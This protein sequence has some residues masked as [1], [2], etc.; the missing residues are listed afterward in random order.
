METK[1]KRRSFEYLLCDP[2]GDHVFLKFTINW[3]SELLNQSV[4]SKAQDRFPSGT[5]PFHI[6]QRPSGPG[7]LWELCGQPDTADGEG[8]H[9]APL[10]QLCNDAEIIQLPGPNLIRADLKMNFASHLNRSLFLES[11]QSEK[12]KTI[13]CLQFAVPPS[14]IC[15]MRPHALPGTESLS[16]VGPASLTLMENKRNI[17]SSCLHWIKAALPALGRIVLAVGG[18]G[19]CG[20]KLEANLPGYGRHWGESCGLSLL[21]KKGPPV[22]RLGP[23]TWQ[24]LRVTS[25]ERMMIEWTT[26]SVVLVLVWLCFTGFGI[27]DSGLGC[28]LN[29]SASRQVTVFPVTLALRKWQVADLHGCYPWGACH[30]IR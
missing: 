15:Y 9:L 25:G 16:P 23:G 19:G 22:P 1:R 3:K 18:Q 10:W 13:K 4:S 26:L 11:F 14:E 24:V 21:K 20:G 30:L 29:H 5:D 7:R 12:E 27:E 2:K 8:E 6:S 17:V 28:V